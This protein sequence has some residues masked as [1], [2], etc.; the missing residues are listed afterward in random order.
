MLFLYTFCFSGE[1]FASVRF[2]PVFVKVST[3]EKVASNNSAARIHGCRTEVNHFQVVFKDQMV[4]K[5]CSAVR[6]KGKYHAV[7]GIFNCSK[8]FYG[9]QLEGVLDT[10][11]QTEVRS[12]RWGLPLSSRNQ[13]SLKSHPNPAKNLLN[14]GYDCDAQTDE[15]ESTM[16]SVQTVVPFQRL[17]NASNVCLIFEKL[18][19]P[20]Q[21]S[22]KTCRPKGGVSTQEIRCLYSGFNPVQKCLYNKTWYHTY[23]L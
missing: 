20:L 23:Y 6:V 4:W 14:V 18:Q 8:K 7:D 19:I 1:G 13:R 12:F 17:F 15:S 10:V 2:K 16:I 22:N 3:G 5:H 11:F 21:I 9:F